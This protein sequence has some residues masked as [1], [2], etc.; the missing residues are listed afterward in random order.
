L[1]SQLEYM[2]EQIDMMTAD[3]TRSKQ[4]LKHSKEH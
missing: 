4:I 3:S 1:N 2:R